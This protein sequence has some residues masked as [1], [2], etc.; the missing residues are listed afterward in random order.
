MRILAGVLE[1]GGGWLVL[2]VLVPRWRVGYWLAGFV[3]A[4]P[5]REQAD[6]DLSGAGGEYQGG[7]GDSRC[8]ICF[9]ERVFRCFC[10][11]TF[12]WGVELL[13][14]KSIH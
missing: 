2:V 5:V 3:D 1:M 8:S 12:R 4:V 9:F 7:G 10:R 14:E 6:R 13:H 11:A